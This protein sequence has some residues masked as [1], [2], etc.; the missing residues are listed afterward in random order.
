MRA[1]LKYSEDEKA[2]KTVVNYVHAVLGSRKRQWVLGVI[3]VR[4]DGHYYLEDTTYSVKISFNTLENVDRECFFTESQVV[5]A[6]GAFDDGI[7]NLFT[8]IQPPL[9]KDKP[10]RFALKDMD[11]FG[12]YVKLSEQLHTKQV[13]PKEQNG[14][15]EPALIVISQIQLDEMRQQ[16]ALQ[17]LL[18]GID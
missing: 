2:H 11:Y 7:F 12:N 14:G 6:E 15:P 1:K 10:S 5:L 3:T 9:L 18:E 16:I 4:E 13:E 8:I 17:K